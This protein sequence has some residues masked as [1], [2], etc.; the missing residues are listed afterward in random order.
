M[1]YEGKS[2]ESTFPFNI[3]SSERDLEGTVLGLDKRHLKTRL[4]LGE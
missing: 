2:G 3:F 1:I 4:E